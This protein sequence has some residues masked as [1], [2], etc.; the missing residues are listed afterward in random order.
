MDAIELYY[1]RAGDGEVVVG[2]GGW[3]VRPAA[4]LAALLPRI[5][6]DRQ[7][8]TFHYRGMGNSE[9]GPDVP[10][11]STLYA[12]DVLGILDRA[13][14]ERAHL[15]GMGGM[16]AIVLGELAILAP[17]RVASAVLH[18]PWAVCD[19]SLRWQIETLRDLHEH[20]GFEAYQKAAAALCFTPA[21]IEEHSQ[22]I[23]DNIWVNL[24]G[25]LRTHLRYIDVCLGHDARDRLH[26]LVAP[27]LLIT[28][29]EADLM[30][31]ARL[32]P[33][34]ASRIPNAE[35]HVMADAPHAFFES[36]EK[37]REFDE[38]VSAFLDRHPIDP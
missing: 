19:T 15:V 5:F 24:R 35:T 33:A 8:L 4:D 17:D 10:H 27:T 36:A 18:E 9:L 6:A 16:G 25:N 30:T 3:G 21:Y 38:V 1:E 2:A 37:V 31:G 28:G 14:V 12:H 32:L 20:V 29:D 11:T 13:G 7:A 34:L 22:Q 23:L 26:R